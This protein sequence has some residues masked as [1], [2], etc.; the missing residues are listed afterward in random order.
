[1]LVSGSDTE[2][3][4]KTLF[5]RRGHSKNPGVDVEASGYLNAQVTLSPLSPLARL[6]IYALHGC[7]CEVAF[8]AAWNW[9]YTRDQRL[10][11]YTSLWSL[12]IYSL[13]IFFMEG[14][15]AWLQQ[16]HFLLLL[17]LTVYTLFIYLWEFSWGVFLRLLEACPWDYSHFKYNLMGLVTL[18]YA[19]PW[20]MA[21]LL[22]EKHVIRNTLKIRLND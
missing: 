18:E 17:R 20:A 7:V 10:P 1:M 4:S 22:A 2:M 5:P 3:E 21:A 15:S 11:G 14:L 19:V 8:T 6:Y 9:Y 13:A 16:R 12:L